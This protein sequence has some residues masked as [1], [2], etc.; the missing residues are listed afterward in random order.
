MLQIVVIWLF[1][2]TRADCPLSIFSYSWLGGPHY[3][4]T[5]LNICTNYYVFRIKNGNICTNLIFYLREVLGIYRCKD[6][7]RFK[8]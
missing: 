6:V 4:F 3:Q 7:V 8:I 1:E 5:R 2:L